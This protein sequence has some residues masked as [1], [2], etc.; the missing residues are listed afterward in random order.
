LQDRIDG[1]RRATVTSVASLGAD[2]GA[3]VLYTV[4]PL[5]QLVLVAALGIAVAAAVPRWLRS[6]PA[7]GSGQA[8]DQSQPRD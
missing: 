2:L 8:R 5:G 3:I 7:P 1:A 4:W 6:E